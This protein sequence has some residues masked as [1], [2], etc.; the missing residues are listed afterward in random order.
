MKL[1]IVTRC[2]P[3]FEPGP[4]VPN[5]IRKQVATARK[6]K[7]SLGAI[8]KD[9]DEVLIRVRNYAGLDPPGFGPFTIAQVHVNDT[10]PIELLNNL[11]EQ[12]NIRRLHPSATVGNRKHSEVP[13]PV[14]RSALQVKLLFNRSLLKDS[15][16]RVR[17]LKTSI[18][19]PS[20][21]LLPIA[22]RFASGSIAPVP[23]SHTVLY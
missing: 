10:V 21:N 22:S 8:T 13:W 23:D 9:S 3:T 6:S 16:A 2:K 15:R 20:G 14:R 17:D 7:T 11:Y 19:L 5:P 18:L 1:A 12:I 4:S